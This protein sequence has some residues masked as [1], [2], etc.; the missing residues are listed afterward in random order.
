M[1]FLRISAFSAKC[2]FYAFLRKRRI[3]ANFRIFR[4]IFI[5]RIYH[6]KS[7][8]TWEKQEIPAD[9]CIFCEIFI[10]RIYYK[11]LP[12]PAEN[13]TLLQIS[14]FSVK[15]S[16]E[17]FIIK[18]RRRLQ[19]TRNSCRFPHFPR[20]FILRISHKTPPPPA[21]N[22]EFLQISAFSAKFYFEDFS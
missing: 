1:E 20:N 2:S 7:F 9:F 5:I 13:A 10:L 18:I 12:P 4:E 16:F 3:A 17:G 8:V 15:F 11:N 14:A 6:K 21:E 19:K 22:A